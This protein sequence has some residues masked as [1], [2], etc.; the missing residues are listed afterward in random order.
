MQKHYAMPAWD[1]G[2]EYIGLWEETSAPSSAVECTAPTEPD[3]VGYIRFSTTLNDWYWPASAVLRFERNW[4][5]QQWHEADVGL[6]LAQDDNA[7][8]VGTVQDWQDYKN[9]LRDWPDH[10][11]ISP[12]SGLRPQKP[13]A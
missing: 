9:A 12:E 6:M 3:K 2:Y 5:D 7:K 1:E 10:P 8:A 11:S 4:R 13:T